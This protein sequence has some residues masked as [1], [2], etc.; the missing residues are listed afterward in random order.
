METTE[1]RLH[2]YYNFGAVDSLG[3]MSEPRALSMKKKKHCDTKKRR[4]TLGSLNINSSQ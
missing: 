4:Y 1:L 2:Y 3:A